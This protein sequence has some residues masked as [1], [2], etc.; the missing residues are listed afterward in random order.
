MATSLSIDCGAI[1]EGWHGD[2][3]GDVSDRA[4]VD[5]ES[6]RLMEVTRR[7]AGGGPPSSMV[8]EGA[9]PRRRGA[10]AVEGPIAEQAGVLGRPVV[11]TSATASAPPMHEDPNVPN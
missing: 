8:V 4:E 10:P 9:P 2:A 3:R 5:D 6:M 11:S 7:S 1:I